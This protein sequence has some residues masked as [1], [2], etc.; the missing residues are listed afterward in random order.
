MP[1]RISVKILYVAAGVLIVIVLFESTV[2]LS[3]KK[4]FTISQSGASRISVSPTLRARS[5]D[6]EEERERWSRHM[7]AAGAERAYEDFKEAYRREHFNDQHLAAHILGELLYEKIGSKGIAVCD[8]TFSFGCYHSFFGRALSNEGA[9]IIKALDDACIEK[10][11]PLGVGCQHGIGHGL[12]EYFGHGELLAA[13]EACQTL[14]WKKPLFGCK[15]GVFMEYNL[16]ILVDSSSAIA[17]LR[18]FRAEQPYEPCPSLPEEFR[19]ACY[20]ALGQW[21][22]SVVGSDFTKIGTLC[23]GV[24]DKEEREACYLGVGN[25]AAPSSGYNVPGTINACK[26]MPGAEGELFCRA[27]ASWAFYAIPEHRSVALTLCGG[28]ES[29]DEHLCA[30]SA[31][32]IGDRN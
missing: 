28:L 25:V 14:S 26:K 31:D 30:E 12:V 17:T 13:L 2:L 20:Y 27:G 16:P 22:A 8:S 9:G 10:Y 24:L 23:R 11:G 4:D 32:L 18:E 15:S 19:Q 3:Q 5:S 7:D 6:L 29:A 21:W 1:K